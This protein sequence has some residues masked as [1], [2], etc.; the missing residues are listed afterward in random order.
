MQEID[1]IPIV[2]HVHLSFRP[3]LPGGL[4]GLFILELL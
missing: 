1:N 2:H 3:H 4:D